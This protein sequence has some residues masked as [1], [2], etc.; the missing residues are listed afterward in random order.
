VDSFANDIDIPLEGNKALESKIK[1][2]IECGQS[3]EQLNKAGEA[4]RSY[5]EAL[6][7]LVSNNKDNRVFQLHINI[8]NLYQLSGNLEE[9][10]RYFKKAYDVA[11]IQEN[12][13][14]Q[15][16]ALVKTAD[17]LLS[18]GE[19]EESTRYIKI[20]D[21]IISEIDYIQG[22]LD[23]YIHLTKIQ[24]IKKEY[25]KA[26]ELCNIALRLCTDDYLLYKGRILNILVELYK[27]I[28]SVDEHLELL[29]QAYECF[30]KVNFRRGLIGVL[31][32]IAYVY[33]GKLQDYEKA[34][35]YYYKVNELCEG[36]ICLEFNVIA[37]V[38]IGEVLFKMLKYDEALHWLKQA[39]A[40]PNGAFMQN[41]KFNNYLLLSQ[42]SLKLYNYEEAY[43]YFMKS[44]EEL[45]KFTY[46][47]STLAYYYKLGASLFASFGQQDSAKAYIKQ[48]LDAV[49]KNESMIKWNVGLQY[50]QMRLKKAKNKGEVLDILQAIEYI[51]SK[52]KNNDEILDA[53][54]DVVIELMNA[55]FMELAYSFSESY[56]HLKPQSVRV[57]LKKEYININKI[58]DR[59]KKDVEEMLTSLKTA[60]DVKNKEIHWRICCALG[61]YY[62]KNNEP[63]KGKVYYQEAYNIVDLTINSVPEEFR[64]GF[65]KFNHM[66]EPFNKL[67]RILNNSINEG[68]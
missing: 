39:L 67:T 38:N 51:F 40:K 7:L 21:N 48:A 18:K 19:L 13:I 24:Y 3:A 9:G 8:G 46:I 23:I 44:N 14:M 43:E 65:M 61:D 31:N 47:E 11:I 5:N 37:Y 1:H 12:K 57:K 45:N 16:D 36:S 55:S 56:N 10:L 33:S 54:Y 41:M 27:D 28:T 60:K 52:Y 53:V 58:E 68:V 32:N 4:I 29:N 17:S 62:F 15:V 34:L 2:L 26:R 66:I 63:G 20:A 50:E 25:Y 30:E 59:E 6:F 22:K 64:E 49:E 35:E 42:T